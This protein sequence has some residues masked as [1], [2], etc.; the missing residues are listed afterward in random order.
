MDKKTEKKNKLQLIPKTEKIYR[1][2]ITNNYKIT[3]NGKI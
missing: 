2:Y 3:T 1:I